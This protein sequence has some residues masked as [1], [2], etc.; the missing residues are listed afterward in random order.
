MKKTGESI[1]MG[2]R[3]LVSS[4]HEDPVANTGAQWEEASA[5]RPSQGRLNENAPTS[6]K[7]PWRK[8]STRSALTRAVAAGVATLGAALLLWNASTKTVDHRG[9]R[10]HPPSDAIPPARGSHM[11]VVPAR[12]ELTETSTEDRARHP[13]LT[14]ASS[15]GGHQSDTDQRGMKTRDFELRDWF[16]FGSGCRARASTPGDVSLQ[17]KASTPGAYR[18]Q[19]ALNSYK[20]APGDPIAVAVPS[21]ARECGIRLAIHPAVG[22]RLRAVVTA[23]IFRIDKPVGPRVRVRGRLVLGDATLA[24]FEK[25][26]EAE[27]VT[28]RLPLPILWSTVAREQ[29]VFDGVACA[30]PKLVGLDLS[31]AVVRQRAGPSDVTVDMNQRSVEIA[32]EFETCGFTEPPPRGSELA[33]S[34][35]RWV[36]H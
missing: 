17:V 7:P 11:E 31:A 18:V 36:A 35:A 32:L 13:E 15:I 27:Q 2:P 21:F 29:S 16:A 26:F 6:A 3:N 8:I 19:I 28:S 25:W 4:S 14:E 33:G 23:P 20:I 24:R 12:P 30:Q 1:E 9:A 34:E 22:R 5:S 10:V